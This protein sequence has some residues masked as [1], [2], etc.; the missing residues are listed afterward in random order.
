MKSVPG[1]G[2]EA[3]DEKSTTWRLG[4][5]EWTCHDRHPEVLR[6]SRIQGASIVCATRDTQLRA[7]FALSNTLRR[8]TTTVFDQ[9]RSQGIKLHVVS[10]DSENAVRSVADQLGISHEDTRACCLPAGKDQFIRDI[11]DMDPKAVVMFVGDGANDAPA[12]KRA[13]VG[14]HMA[15]GTDVA[16]AAAS[17]VLVRPDL[18]GV[19]VAIEISKAAYRRVVFNFSWSG[20]YNV[21]AL[22]M[23]AGA[24]VKFRIPPAYAALGEIVSVLPVI[25]IALS[26][27]WRKFGQKA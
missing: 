21:L 3:E 10:G 19:L 25:A 8:E 23:A 15:E 20:I 2:I 26:L 9:L 5:P 13:H 1:K 6:I 18:R 24:W 22:T 12:L 16:G 11:C 14:V 7:V 4:S 27:R 17:V